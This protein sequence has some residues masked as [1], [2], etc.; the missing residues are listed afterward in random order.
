MTARQACFNG[1][2]VVDMKAAAY[3]RRRLAWRDLAL[4]IALV[5]T[6]PLRDEISRKGAPDGDVATLRPTPTARNWRSPRN[7]RKRQ[8][9]PWRWSSHGDPLPLRLRAHPLRGIRRFPTAAPP[10]QDLV[11]GLEGLGDGGER[12]G[13][14]GDALPRLSWPLRRIWG[15]PSRAAAGAG[16]P[17]MCR[18]D[19]IASGW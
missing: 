11:G 16:A 8:R 5:S 12:R 13:G 7:W 10:R 9:R 2:E 17:G 14:S 3:T 4:Q 6:E 19:L 18:E 15:R 1:G